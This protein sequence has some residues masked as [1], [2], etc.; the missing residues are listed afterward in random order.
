MLTRTLSQLD[1]FKED[2]IKNMLELQIQNY[3]MFG[4]FLD[5]WEFFKTRELTWETSDFDFYDLLDELFHIGSKTFFRKKSN[6]QKLF[7]SPI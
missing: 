5:L 4:L 6:Y 2:Q 7:W 1:G 3:A